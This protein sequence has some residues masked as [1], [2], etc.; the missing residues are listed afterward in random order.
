MPDE[1]F[2]LGAEVIS[3]DGRAIGK[4]AHLLVGPDYGL[5]A[6]VVKESAAFSGHRFSPGSYLVNDEF[7]VP[8]NAARSVT[9]ER[10]ELSLSAAD[11]RLLP[12]YLSYREK[13]ESTTEVAADA[14]GPLT[15]SPEAP[16]WVEQVANKPADSLEIDGGENVMLGHSGRKLGT[17]KDVLFDDDQLV[18][19]VIQP[20]GFFRGDVIL[21][22]RFLDRS[23]DA[24]LFANIEEA[25][26][27]RLTTF[28]PAD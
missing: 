25:D 21:P 22:R 4:L 11:A 13:D 27:E 9:H 20:E 2:H 10:V 1:D 5:R 15:A 17:V 18:G 19:V 26:V 12:P 16:H 3:S 24:A 7:V 28:K 23:D 14:V 8:A 6:L